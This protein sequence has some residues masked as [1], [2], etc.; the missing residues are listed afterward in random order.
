V[1]AA[2]ATIGGFIIHV[3]MGTRYGPGRLHVDH[4]RRSLLSLGEDAPSPL[5]RA[6]HQEAVRGE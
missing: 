2:L 6:G 4:S 1:T 5:V 3:Y